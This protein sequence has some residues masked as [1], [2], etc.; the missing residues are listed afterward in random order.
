MNPVKEATKTVNDMLKMVGEEPI[1]LPKE[2]STKQ[3]LET[4]LEIYT[5]RLIEHC[6][7][8]KKVKNMKDIPDMIVIYLNKM[9]ER[10]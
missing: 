8:Y 10:H 2:G 4:L 3:R 1:Q 7:Q 6:P 9:I 5:G